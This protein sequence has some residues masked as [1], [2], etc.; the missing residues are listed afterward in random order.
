MAMQTCRCSNLERCPRPYPRRSEAMH[1]SESPTWRGRG[2]LPS[3]TWSGTSPATVCLEP[4]CV[5]SR[6]SPPPPFPETKK[7]GV[8]DPSK[9]GGIHTRSCHPRPSHPFARIRGARVRRDGVS[10]SPTQGTGGAEGR[11]ESAGASA[12]G[13]QGAHERA[14]DLS[15]TEGAWPSTT[16]SRFTSKAWERDSRTTS[17]GP[18]VRRISSKA[19]QADL[20]L[21]RCVPCERP[22]CCRSREVCKAL[23]WTRPW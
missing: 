21:R 1:L 12:P 8:L 16:V 17:L 19:R 3:A 20:A 18:H 10:G 7:R 2:F 6:R 11:W 14:D 23:G 5:V 22:R 13:G 4:S 15:R 9:K